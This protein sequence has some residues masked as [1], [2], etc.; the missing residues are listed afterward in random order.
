MASF[1]SRVLNDFQVHKSMYFHTVNICQRSICE[2]S[3]PNVCLPSFPSSDLRSC[4]L[5]AHFQH[6]IWCGTYAAREKPQTQTHRTYSR[7]LR[8]TSQVS[9]YFLHQQ[10][11]LGTVPQFL[12]WHNTLIY[13][14]HALEPH[15]AGEMAGWVRK[16]ILFLP[17]TCVQFPTGNSQPSD[18][19]SCPGTTS[20]SSGIPRYHTYAQTHTDHTSTNN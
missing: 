18:Y 3:A 19:N 15:R 2:N 17:K 12:T 4:P 13:K 11:L 7:P 1:A 16:H 8:L 6:F 10:P 14:L 20:P 9:L 5:A